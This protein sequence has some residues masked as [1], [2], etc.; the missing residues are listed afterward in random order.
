A[1]T[2]VLAVELS[3]GAD[4]ASAARTA[5]AAAALTVTRPGPATSPSA[6]DLAAFL[7]RHP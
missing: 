6:G 4:P 5:N 3:R 1:H 2:G 7:A